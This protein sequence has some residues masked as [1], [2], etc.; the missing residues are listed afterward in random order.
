MHCVC[1]IIF[2]KKNIFKS[3]GMESRAIE[4][5]TVQSEETIYHKSE[6]VTLYK[7]ENKNGTKLVVSNF[8]ATVVSLFVKDKNGVLLDVILGYENQSDYF[9]DEFYF[10]SVVGRYAN[11]IAGDTVVIDNISYK[12]SSKAAGYHLHGGEHGFNKK[13]FNAAPFYTDDKVGLILTY[14]SP[15]LEEGFPGNLKL[16]VIY[17]LDDDDNW[18]VEYKAV[19]DKTTILNL[20]QHTYFN[21]SGNLNTTIDNHYLK[22]NSNYYLPVNNAQVPIGIF[23]NVANS[24]FDFTSL[25]N[26]GKDIHQ[27]EEQLKLSN[28]YDH[29]W[30]LERDNDIGLKNAATLFEANTGIRLDVLTTEPSIH[31]YTG[32][33]LENIIGKNGVVYNKRSGVCLETQ[34]F[35][36]S[37]NNPN[38]PTTIIKAGEEF[39][40]KT[41]FKFSTE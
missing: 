19:S 29:T 11:R 31:I 9:N 34:H 41:V 24:V 20:T 6:I 40:S 22:I 28:G 8:G 32:N 35:P 37:P 5:P 23:K 18:M 2:R 33:F 36:D 4:T 17:T 16:V 1:A 30:I 27:K 39:Y 38:F 3:S 25:K 12:L 21:L 13:I 15:H 7:L 14:T 26:I 10:G